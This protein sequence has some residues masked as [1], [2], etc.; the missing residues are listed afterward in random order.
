MAAPFAFAGGSFPGTAGDCTATL[1]AGA[2]CTI[3]IT[4]SPTL[5]GADADTIDL[6]YNDGVSLQSATRDLT[7]TGL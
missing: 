6:N 4:Y 7:G 2:N 3:V 5:V 1:A